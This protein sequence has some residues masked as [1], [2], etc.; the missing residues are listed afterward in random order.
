MKLK[1][2][3][4]SGTVTGSCYFLSSKNTGVMID[5]GMFQGVK[6][7]ESLNKAKPAID[8]GKLDAVVLTHAHLDH[9]GKLPLLLKYG[10]DGH[11]Y[12]NEPTKA[13]VEIVLLDSAKIAREDSTETL[14]D[15]DD[16][17][18][19]LKKIVLVDYH[20]PFSVG[21]FEVEMY[22]AGH[23]LGSTSLLFTESETK[24]KILFS[25]DLGN[26]PE[27]LLHSTEFVNEAD[28]VVMESTYGD[29]RHPAGNEADVI[30]DIVSQAEHIGATVIIPTFSIQRAQELLYVFDGLKKDNKVSNETVVFLDS[31]MALRTTEVYKDY[32]GLFSMKL[33]NQVKTDDP[34]DFPGLVLCD[35]VEKSKQIKNY[36]GTKVVIAGSGMMTGGRIMH[37]AINYLSD[38]KN[39]LIF[40]GYQAEGTLGREILSGKTEVNIWGNVVEIRSAIKE[41]KTM[42]SHADQDQLWDWFS[43]INGVSKVF[44]T[45]GEDIARLVFKEV[46]KNKNESPVDVEMPNIDQEFEL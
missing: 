12:M 29:E 21:D 36:Q 10:F 14:Y 13:L 24:K 41:I 3:G 35:S 30:A 39:T 19:L 15:E 28:F 17:F 2:L 42:S 46:I 34:F 4:A 22:D 26:S 37:H 5:S 45:H 40:V 43:K 20:K 25:G 6:D 11:I 18:S 33:K 9:C 8:F 27:P 32:P 16:V 31:P 23:I 7:S 38:P 1:F 44:L